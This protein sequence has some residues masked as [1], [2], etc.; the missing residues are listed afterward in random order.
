MR[1]L[2]LSHE[3]P[4]IGGGGGKAAQDLCIGFAKAGHE[5]KVVTAHYGDLPLDEVQDGVIIHQVQ[6]IQDNDI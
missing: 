4:P 1:I 6:L 3:Y 5:V 2:T